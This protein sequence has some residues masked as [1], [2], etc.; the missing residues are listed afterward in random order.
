L[1][2]YLTLEQQI[3]VAYSLSISGHKWTPLLKALEV[4]FIKFR[5]VIAL[6]P[7]KGQLIAFT[8]KYNEIGSDLLFKA[9]E[10]PT[11]QVEAVDAK[12]PRM[13]RD[14]HYGELEYNQNKQITGKVNH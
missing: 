5:K 11:I 14:K 4:N 10:D 13:D 12:I 8:Y 6:E 2:R 7:S 1:Y 3:H 9:L